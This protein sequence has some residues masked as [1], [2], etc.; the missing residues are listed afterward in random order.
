MTFPIDHSPEAFNN[1]APWLDFL[2][3]RMS[4]RFSEGYA[5]YW[6]VFL[7]GLLGD[8]T[9]QLL[10]D[11]LLLPYPD[12]EES[13]EDAL[14]LIGEE[15][16]I[17]RYA[18][19]S[20]ESYRKRVQQFWETVTYFGTERAIADFFEVAGYGIPFIIQ[21]LTGTTADIPPYKAGPTIPAY[22]STKQHWSQFNVL[23]VLNNPLG[24]GTESD[25]LSDA[26]LA[27]MRNFL[28]HSKPVDWVVREIILSL[29]PG[30]SD[31]RFYGDGSKYDGSF[32]YQDGDNLPPQTAYERHKGMV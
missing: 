26:Q 9:E 20:S 11:S 3:E 17:I 27:T 21:G 2:S 5:G 24:S 1:R 16:G 29:R 25:L 18:G 23:L 10:M 7:K 31:L 22:P 12:R 14:K 30:I 15:N 6:Y 4:Y 8:T 19:E 28:R 32:N 13:P